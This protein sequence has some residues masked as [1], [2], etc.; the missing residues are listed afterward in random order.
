MLRWGRGQ[1]PTK[2]QC[3]SFSPGLP[4]QD[5]Q[6][7][8]PPCLSTSP[9]TRGTRRPGVQHLAMQ[10]APQRPQRLRALLRILTGVPRHHHTTAMDRDIYCCKVQ[11]SLGRR[12]HPSLKALPKSCFPV[13]LCATL[14]AISRSHEVTSEYGISVRVS[15]APCTDANPPFLLYVLP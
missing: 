1:D 9:G 4:T 13:R 11:L 5:G 7:W 12:K 10:P 15:L 6:C 3:T 8:H 14:N 2:F